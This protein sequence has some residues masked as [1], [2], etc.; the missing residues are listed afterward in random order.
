M[1]NDRLAPKL[2]KKIAIVAVAAIAAIAAACS[3]RSVPT[4]SPTSLQPDGVSPAMAAAA[5]TLPNSFIAQGLLR[6]KP[7][8]QAVSVTKV[9]PSG[10]GSVQVPGTDFELQIPN[11]AFVGTNMKFTVTALAGAAVAYDFEPHGSVFRV[12]LKFVQHL[13]HTNLKGVNATPGFISQVTGAYFPNASMVDPVTGMAIVT[14]FLPANITW[15]GDEL[16]FPISHFSGYM[17]ATGRR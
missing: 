15:G 17:I 13:S 9:I 11:G 8:A 5:A 14:E 6:E 16:S 3:D 12:P 1:Q 7:L 10:G 2:S 4:A